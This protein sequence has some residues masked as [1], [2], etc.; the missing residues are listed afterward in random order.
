ME[1]TIFSTLNASL[2]ATA[3]V[4]FCNEI[5]VEVTD[6]LVAILTNAVMCAL[7][8]WYNENG[9]EFDLAKNLIEP[10]AVTYAFGRMH[11]IA[12]LAQISAATG[13]GMEGLGFN[14]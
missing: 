2:L 13:I 4:K 14:E 3:S 6:E 10:D 5:G 1:S 9:K 7:A 8:R 11:E 12:T